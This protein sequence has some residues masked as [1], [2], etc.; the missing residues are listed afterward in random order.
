MCL[1][2]NE[3]CFTKDIYSCFSWPDFTKRIA[4]EQVH[5][6]STNVLR[7][8]AEVT[9]ANTLVNDFQPK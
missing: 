1:V 8:Y 9:S 6:A 2:G 4:E 7:Q 5:I 3:P